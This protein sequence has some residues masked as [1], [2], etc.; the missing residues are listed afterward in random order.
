MFTFVQVYKKSEEAK[1]KAYA[2]A[3]SED[4]DVK[5]IDGVDI[6][7]CDDFT[8]NPKVCNSGGEFDYVVVIASKKPIKD[9]ES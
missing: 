7:L 1:A 5:W 3:M 4:H 6:L 9:F 2:Q 8:P